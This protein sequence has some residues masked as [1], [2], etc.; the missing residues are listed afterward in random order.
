MKHLFVILT[1]LLFTSL[2]FAQ[3]IDDVYQD[4]NLNDADIEQQFV[5]GG[6]DF[7]GNEAYVDQ[8][9]NDNESDVYQDNNGHAG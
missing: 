7:D 1:L 6:T 3:H 8:I 5:G 9:G 4:G 2:T